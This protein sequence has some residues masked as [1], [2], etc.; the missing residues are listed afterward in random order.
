MGE[1]EHDQCA[2]TK[3]LA[4][5]GAPR[6]G[7]DRGSRRGTQGAC[8]TTPAGGRHQDRATGARERSHGAMGEDRS[9][10]DAGAST[11]ARRPIRGRE[12]SKEGAEG[13]GRTGAGAS[14]ASSPSEISATMDKLL[15]L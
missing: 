10:D 5:T 1:L 3:E 4:R 14:P 7:T 13:D 15:E 8:G 9:R 6:L 2:S 12:R 11:A